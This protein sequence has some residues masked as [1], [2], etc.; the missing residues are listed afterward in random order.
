MAILIHLGMRP[1]SR[2]DIASPAEQTGSLQ[3]GSGRL[4]LPQLLLADAFAEGRLA[5]VVSKTVGYDLEAYVTRWT[6]ALISDT[7][8]IFLRWLEG[9][10]RTASDL[11]SAD[12]GGWAWSSSAGGL[13]C[14]LGRINPVRRAISRGEAPHMREAP[15]EC[16]FVDRQSVLRQRQLPMDRF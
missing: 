12:H 8:R 10:T 9:I 3:T 11:V 6:A 4:R 5:R 1:P 15:F 13:S 16:H 14:C 2:R 7:R